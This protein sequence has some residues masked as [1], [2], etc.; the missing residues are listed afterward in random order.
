MTCLIILACSMWEL[1]VYCYFGNE[2]ILQSNFL[3]QSIY[4]S[5]WYLMDKTM[6]LNMSI[7]M[8][9]VNKPI[10]LKAGRFVPL[11]I[12]TLLMVLKAAYSYYTFL[13]NIAIE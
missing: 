2:I 8:V 11:S 6:L 3:S 12:N 9:R 13:R 4:L 7:M 10:I 5:D 1:T